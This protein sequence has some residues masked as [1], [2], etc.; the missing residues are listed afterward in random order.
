MIL[1]Q[2]NE[3][4][5]AFTMLESYEFC[6]P[7]LVVNNYFHKAP[8]Q[9]H[10]ENISYL[11][12]TSVEVSPQF[13]YDPIHLLHAS[14]DL[15]KL[16]EACYVLV[17]YIEDIED[18]PSIIDEGELRKPCLEK[19]LYI[20]WQAENSAW[21]CHPHNISDEEFI[22]PYL[23]LATFFDYQSF[24]KW[25]RTL[26][27]IFEYSLSEPG[28]DCEKIRFKIDTLKVKEL[29]MK[30]IEAAYLIDVRGNMTKVN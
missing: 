10:R 28:L 8:L 29:F 3:H 9:S 25:K 18:N 14:Q 15:E 12:E 27:H 11:I 1:I 21:N 6:K 4:S 24:S 13:K 26:H 20:G 17:K 30:I 22:N 2:D 7:M 19:R 23:A 16:I 5:E